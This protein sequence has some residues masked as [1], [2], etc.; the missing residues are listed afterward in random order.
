M[1]TAQ[2]PARSAARRA[3]PLRAA[4]PAA[5]PPAACR[6]GGR[7]PR[8]RTPGCARG[9]WKPAARRP[10]P[11]P[12]EGG[13]GPGA[14]RPGSA[15]GASSGLAGRGAG[16]RSRAARPLPLPLAAAG[17]PSWARSRGP[18]PALDCDFERES[19]SFTS[20][21]RGG[22][23]LFRKGCKGPYPTP[24]LPGRK[25]RERG[26]RGSEVLLGLALRSLLPPHPEVA[27]FQPGSRAAAI[28]AA[29]P[30]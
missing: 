5:P 13:G 18:Q 25:G 30:G 1:G 29:A 3:P 15:R 7:D 9:A 14:S 16:L 20:G 12:R 11:R 8:A 24:H 27:S 17:P 4:G 23:L 22:E 26:L 19:G 2:S 10:R 21:L 6:G 28:V